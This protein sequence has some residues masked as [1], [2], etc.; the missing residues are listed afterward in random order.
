MRDV[1]AGI[2][3]GKDVVRALA[4]GATAVF[5]GRPVFW[6]LALGGEDGLRR[7][8][9]IMHDEL[10]ICMQLCGCPT[11]ADINRKHVHDR[12]EQSVVPVVGALVAKDQ[13]IESLRATI[14]EL[15][16]LQAQSSLALAK[17]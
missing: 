7:L 6:G 1:T 10:T 11:I 2:R 15:R 9:E 3:R 8:F 12:G 4:L 16:L 5:I 17:L 14:R 13:E